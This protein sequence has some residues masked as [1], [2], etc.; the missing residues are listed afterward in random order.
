MKQSFYLVQIGVSYSSPCF[1]P[2]SAG[3]IAA[4]L[5]QDKEICEAYE[6]PDIVVMREEVP[7]VLLRFH[8]P[9]IVAFSCYIWNFEY[10]KTVARELKALYPDV[11]IVFGGHQVSPDG[12]MLEEYDYIDFLQHGE[13]E[14][15]TALFLKA[16]K[17]GADLR[18]VPGLSFREDGR[19]VTTPGYTPCDLSAYPSPYLSGVFDGIMREFPDREFHATLETNRGCPYECA[20]CEWCFTKKLRPFPAD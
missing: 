18:T 2:Y 4:Y 7:A 17:N 3:C 16:L 11:K 10:N 8:N 15:C 19:V 9:S 12:A 13:G 14:E 5:K 20:Y 1:L 6:I